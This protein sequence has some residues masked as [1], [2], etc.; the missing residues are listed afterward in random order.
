MAYKKED[1]KKLELAESDYISCE[2]DCSHSFIDT[3]DAD[4]WMRLNPPD[5]KAVIRSSS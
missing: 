5:L 2:T 4:D 3:K 1:L